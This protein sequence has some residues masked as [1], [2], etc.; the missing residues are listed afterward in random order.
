M[1]GFAVPGS[2]FG[3]QE[4]L[5]NDLDLGTERRSVDEGAV[6]VADEVPHAVWM[7]QPESRG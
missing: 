3:F 4:P 5:S 2:V 1:G 6:K 7:A